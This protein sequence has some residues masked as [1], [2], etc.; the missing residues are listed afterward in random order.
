MSGFHLSGPTKAIT[1]E[2]VRDPGTFGLNL[3]LP[4]H[5]SGWRALNALERSYGETMVAPSAVGKGL[6][7]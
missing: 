6:T 2:T 1:S 7:L 4:A 5:C 3:I